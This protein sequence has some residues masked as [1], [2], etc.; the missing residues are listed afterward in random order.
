MIL[1]YSTVDNL[2]TYLPTYGVGVVVGC[3]SAVPKKCEFVIGGIG[4]GAGV[5]NATVLYSVLYL[6]IPLLYRYH[7]S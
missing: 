6:L 7:T 2:P 3:S 1:E 5:N 4:G